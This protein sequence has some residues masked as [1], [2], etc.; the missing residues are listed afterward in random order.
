MLI[1][2]T[3]GTGFVA[4]WCISALLEQGHSVRTTVRSARSETHLK[5]VFGDRPELTFAT[6]DLTSDAGW[7]AAMNGVG[8]V[9]HVASP[10]TG[11]DMLTPARDGT[12][13]VLS[14]AADAGVKRV[15]MT[16]SCA[17]ATPPS[18]EEGV[19]DEML[20]TDPSS[21]GIDAYRTSKLMAER[22][23]WEVAQERQLSLTTVLPGAVFGPLL[24]TGTAGSVKVIG[25]M[26]QGMPGVPRIG[27][28]IV[29]VRDLAE[30]HILALTNPQ[31]GGERY[32]AV[33]EHLWMK[34]VAEVL[35]EEL[36]DKA[37]KVSKRSIPDFAI[38]ALVKAA[39]DAKA[40]IPMLGRRYEYT[41]AK[42][43]TLGWQPRPA[44]ETVVDCAES[45]L[46]S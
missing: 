7:A 41:N 4:G 43:R 32:I 26:L 46:V 31:A 18:G 17:A 38:K 42:A 44:R 36:G 5:Q 40:L 39:P 33:S 8:G 9:L 16:S 23:A 14:A 15:V 13:R 21:A 27:L 1:L 11:E 2:V 24:S 10:M 20:W 19:F 34:E 12:R 35:R 22:T 28:N 30:L 29:D 3:G 25:Q 45:L 6:A 37:S